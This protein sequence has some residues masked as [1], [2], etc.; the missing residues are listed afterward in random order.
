MNDLHMKTVSHLVMVQ[1]LQEPPGGALT[2]AVLLTVADNAERHRSA[3]V[4]LT[5]EQATRVAEALGGRAPVCRC[6][7]CVIAETVSA[8]DPE[9]SK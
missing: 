4:T 7:Q 6:E 9:R 2:G 8:D 1:F 3:S 5:R